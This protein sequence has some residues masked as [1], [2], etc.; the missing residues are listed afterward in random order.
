MAVC[1]TH[2]HND[3]CAHTLVF[4]LCLWLSAFGS[5]CPSLFLSFYIFQHPSPAPHHPFSTTEVTAGGSEEGKGRN[6][7]PR[8]PLGAPVSLSTPL[9]GQQL[10]LGG[11]SGSQEILGWSHLGCV[12]VLHSSGLPVSGQQAGRQ[13]VIRQ[14]PHV[15]RGGTQR[16][17][18][19]VDKVSTL[20]REGGGVSRSQF[21]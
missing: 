19:D 6:K 9:L 8:R 13:L 20:P 17:S 5:S 16:C 18:G 7:E 12:P 15:A 2:L 14:V 3:L 10:S 1:T 21:I 4:S 11:G